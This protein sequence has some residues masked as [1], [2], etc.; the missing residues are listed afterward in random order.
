M[1]VLVGF[2]FGPTQK[3]AFSFVL[4]SHNITEWTPE[5]P[6]VYTIGPSD[7]SAISFFATL[8]IVAHAVIQEYG[9]DKI[10]KKLHLSKYRTAQFIES[11]H[12]VIFHV[13]SQ[14][15]LVVILARADWLR[16]YD[17]LWS[18]YPSG[19]NLM[20]YQEKFLFIAHLSYWL[21]CYTA[22]PLHRVRRED[23]SKRIAHYTIN[24]LFVVFVYALGYSRLGLVMLTV[25]GFTEIIFHSARIVYNFEL[26]KTNIASILY[27]IWDV[28]FVIARLLTIGISVLVLLKPRAVPAATPTASP[29]AA[30]GDATTTEE[31]IG[32]P[33]PD[34]AGD[35]QARLRVIV[36][37]C[38]LV[39]IVVGNAWMLLNFATFQLRRSQAQAVVK[40][41]AKTKKARTATAR[42]G[43]SPESTESETSGGE[44]QRASP[45][46]TVRQRK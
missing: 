19:R 2:I 4:M 29:D 25:H 15:W 11:T 21:H 45:K 12:L 26:K 8:C 3:L 44:E 41:G 37:Y 46:S 20:S 35:S 7:V 24:L 1:F 5:L 36:S 38:T 33:P 6:E 23:W 22:L 13:F 31:E 16:K 30:S 28:A 42:A 14:C 32:S 10:V 9:V 43:S 39:I 40:G 34:P 18:D 17:L 27:S